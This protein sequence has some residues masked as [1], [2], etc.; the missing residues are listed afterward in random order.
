MGHNPQSLGGALGSVNAETESIT[1]ELLTLTGDVLRNPD[2]G[3]ALAAVATCGVEHVGFRH[4]VVLGPDESGLMVRLL[5]A[6]GL[7][8]AKSR[9]EILAYTRGLA[10][11]AE[12]TKLPVGV[13]GSEQDPRFG[14]PPAGAA[15]A[16]ACPL[17]DG[18][19]VCGVLVATLSP[20]EDGSPPPLCAE[21]LGFLACLATEVLVRS[22][23]RRQRGDLR[24]RLEESEKARLQ[25]ERLA[26][27]GELVAEMAR[28]IQAPLASLSGFASRL[29]ESLEPEDERRSVLD[30]MQREVERLDRL[31]GDQV[32]MARSPDPELFPDDINRVLEECLLLESDTIKTRRIRLSRRL[33]T[34][35]PTLL[36]DLD[37]MRRIFLNI[38]RGAMER[39]A[40]GGRLKVESKRKGNQV[41][42]TVAADVPRGRGETLEQMWRPFLAEGKRPGDVA[43]QALERMLTQHHGVLQVTSDAEWPLLFRLCLPIADNRDRRRPGTD[44]RRRSRRRA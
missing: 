17:L 8:E 41:E 4:L 25:A 33:S 19:A 12:R 35:L 2:V 37:L 5:A 23:L 42:V 29:S 27:V 18:D 43:A 32:E 13:T 26:A 28:E 6:S 38:L 30:V 15:A 44:R 11:W 21:E 1:A 24:H 14:P 22:M 20:D 10:S 3:S 16:L 40:R 39:M 34:S 31:V 36:L 9:P 7:E